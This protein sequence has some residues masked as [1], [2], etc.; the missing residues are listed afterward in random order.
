[1]STKASKEKPGRKKSRR[2]SKKASKAK[3]IY[4]AGEVVALYSPEAEDQIQLFALKED[5]FEV[6]Q[7]RIKTNL[8]NRH[9]PEE[10]SSEEV[11]KKSIYFV[12]GPYRVIKQAR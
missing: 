5:V 9:R 2:R 1:M 6:D 7:K 10:G 8:L 3:A 4:S 11:D 12:P